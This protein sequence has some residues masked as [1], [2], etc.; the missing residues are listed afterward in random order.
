MPRC[1]VYANGLVHCSVCVNHNMTI[2]TI[3]DVVN[4]ENPTGTENRWHVD[5]A[6]TFAD[7]SPNPHPCER[8]PFRLHY[9]MVC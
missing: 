9:L 4:D 5:N 8:E 7:G 3:E 2:S 6:P 1:F